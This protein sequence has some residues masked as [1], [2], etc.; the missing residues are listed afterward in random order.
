MNS[1]RATSMLICGNFY[2]NM[3]TQKLHIKRGESR[4]AHELWILYLY[5]YISHLIKVSEGD[6]S[7]TRKPYRFLH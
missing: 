3:S 5:D 6:N 2:V 7:L 4:K 1:G